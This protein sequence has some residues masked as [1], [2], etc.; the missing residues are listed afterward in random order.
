ME[1]TKFTPGPWKLLP[2]GACNVKS[3]S[4]RSI[5][6]TSVYTT[7]TDNGEHISENEANAKLIAATPELLE[8]LKN[9]INGIN[10]QDACRGKFYTKYGG[11][12]D[13]AYVGS[14]STPSDEQILKAIEA[15][16]KATE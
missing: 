7:N 16:K 15:I 10:P 14:K 4:G 1:N 8:A 6:T 5:C 9:L 13:K 2:Y 12:K 3:E 11:D